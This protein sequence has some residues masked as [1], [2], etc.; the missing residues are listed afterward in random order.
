[1]NRT[2]GAPKLWALFL[3]VPVLAACGSDDSS[4][5]DA[6]DTSVLGSAMDAVKDTASS[7]ADAVGDAASDAKDAAGAMADQAGDMAGNAAD[8]VTDA[9]KGAADMAGDAMDSAADAAGAAVDTVGDAA[10]GAADMAG[11]AVDS[12]KDAAGAA[13]DAVGDAAK[14]AATMAGDAVDS[15]K[16]A[17][18]AAVAAVTSGPC[19]LSITAGDSMA[20]STNALTVPASCDTIT[21]TLTH[22]GSLPKAAMGHNWVLVPA[23]SADTVAAAGISAGVDGNYLPSDDRIIAATS[24][25]GG[26]ESASVSFDASK[27][28]AGTDYVYVCTFPGHWTVM[29]GTFAITG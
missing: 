29:K 11:D 25:V 3:L 26:G 16:D 18:G 23:A 10:K 28:K 2:I 22:T 1:M 24:L 27:L 13:A 14:G 12:A 8:S 15:A 4:S 17:A 9:A 20:Y 21:V 6:E 7:A 5:D 19:A